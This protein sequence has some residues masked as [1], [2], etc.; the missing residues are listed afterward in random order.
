MTTDLWMLI[1][2]VLFSFTLIMISPTVNILKRGPLW[3]MGNR[4]DAQ[5][6]TGWQARAERLDANMRE[7]LP[8]FA[9]L[10]IVVHITGNANETSALGATIFL[11]GRVVHALLFLA[12]VP[13]LRT[14]AW[15]V[16]V[17]GMVMV[18]TAL[19]P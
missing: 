9:I 14:V 5:A 16:A 4:E 8:L 15:T 1:F 7:N 17:A 11:A 2:T 3:A 6:A 19:L 12:G 10:V 18:G 13:V